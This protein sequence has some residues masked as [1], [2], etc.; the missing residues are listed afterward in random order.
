MQKNAFK[1]DLTV[2]NHGSIF[3]LELR[4]D[5]AVAWVE[6]RSCRV[7]TRARGFAARIP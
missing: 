2:I 5:A 7:R 6:E 4:T 1:A 3:L